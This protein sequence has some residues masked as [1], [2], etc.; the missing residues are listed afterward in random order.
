MRPL[1]TEISELLVG[2]VAVFLQSSAV[3]RKNICRAVVIE[4]ILQASS[5]AFHLILYSDLVLFARALLLSFLLKMADHHSHS[6]HGFYTAVDVKLNGDNYK[7]WAGFV[8]MILFGLELLFHIDGTPPEVASSADSADSTSSASVTGR[9]RWHS[10]DRRACAI[11]SQSLEPA[12]RQGG[13]PS[14]RCPADVGS[15]PPDV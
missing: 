14:Y 13:F 5:R 9:T 15:P 2:I 10:D 4:H 8:R 11:I 6:S 1:V 3:K 12:V 7:I